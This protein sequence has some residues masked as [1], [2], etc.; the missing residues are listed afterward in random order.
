[1]G[2]SAMIDNVG[3]HIDGTAQG[4]RLQDDAVSVTYDEECNCSGLLA[5]GSGIA[6]DAGVGWG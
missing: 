5:L 3:S 2:L 1:M 6:V 4:L